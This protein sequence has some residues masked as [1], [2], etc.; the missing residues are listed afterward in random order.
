MAD[1]SAVA[2]PSDFAKASTDKMA[3]KGTEIG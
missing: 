1:R 2:E 3:D